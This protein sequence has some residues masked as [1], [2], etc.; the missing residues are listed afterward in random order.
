MGVSYF[1]CYLV[2]TVGIFM[3][4]NDVQ[5]E[6]LPADVNLDGHRSALICFSSR[7]MA[8]AQFLS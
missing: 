2:K 6:V 4:R 3:R 7:N 1:L 8:F 5:M